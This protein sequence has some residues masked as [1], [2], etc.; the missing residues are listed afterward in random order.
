[1]FSHEREGME[2]R[3]KE[4]LWVAKC[5]SRESAAV[6]LGSLRQATVILFTLLVQAP[7]NTT[8]HVT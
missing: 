4:P 5:Q 3:N 6:I 1:M 7:V 2:D 8:T